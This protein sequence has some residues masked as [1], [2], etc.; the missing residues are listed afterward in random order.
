MVNHGLQMVL[1]RGQMRTKLAP[2]YLNGHSSMVVVHHNGE[3][4]IE[5]HLICMVVQHATQ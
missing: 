2:C 3:L 1:N 4:K 5:Q